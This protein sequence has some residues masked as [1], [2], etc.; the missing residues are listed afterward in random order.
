[1]Q[2]SIVEFGERGCDGMQG[3]VHTIILRRPATIR[4]IAL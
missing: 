2:F 4:C 3:A 1:V